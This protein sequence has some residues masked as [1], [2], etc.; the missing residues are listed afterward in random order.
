[1]CFP[2]HSALF[3]IFIFFPYLIDRSCPSIRAGGRSGAFFQLFFQYWLQ[4]SISFPCWVVINSVCWIV[5]DQVVSFPISDPKGSLPCVFN[6]V[7]ISSLFQFFPRII[8]R[9]SVWSKSLGGSI[10]LFIAKGTLTIKSYKYL[11]AEN[12]TFSPNPSP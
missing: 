11:M 5:I 1:M 4:P 6:L 3:F 8:F 10:S 2:T 7:T 12:Y 9:I